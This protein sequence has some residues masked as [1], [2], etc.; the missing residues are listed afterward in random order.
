MHV[1]FKVCYFE[2]TPRFMFKLLEIVDSFWEY[3]LSE[4]KIA[5][6]ER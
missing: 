5:I 3:Y 6:C 1:V 2:A 4:L